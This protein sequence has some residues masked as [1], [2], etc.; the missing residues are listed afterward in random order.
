VQDILKDI[1]IGV[2]CS[3]SEGLSNSIMEYM[4]AGLPVVATDV[5]G[6]PELVRHG[7]TGFLVPP[8]HEK[9][10]AEALRRVIRSPEEAAKMG[11]AGRKFI[12][13]EFGVDRMI[14]QTTEL[15]RFTLRDKHK[16]NDPKHWRKV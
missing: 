11:T 3:D 9:A 5:G 12:L 4:A 7:E 10:L 13:K 2:I 16:L 8:N 1:A 6:N 14:D 15:Y